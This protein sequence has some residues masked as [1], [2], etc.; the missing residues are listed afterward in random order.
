M[1]PLPQ[2]QQRCVLLRLHL[3]LIGPVLHFTAWTAA[4]VS[5]TT[6]RNR[7]VPP[8][9]CQIQTFVAAAATAVAAAIH[10]EGFVAAA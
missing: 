10:G 7:L 1:Q 4:D 3:K 6:L 8:N 5:D 9:K 2:S